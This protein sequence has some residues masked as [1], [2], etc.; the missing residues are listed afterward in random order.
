[1]NNNIPWVEKYRPKKIDE[2]IQQMEVIKILKRTLKTGD[3]P[4]MLFYGP[5]GT[6]KTSTILAIVYELFGPKNINNRVIELNASDDN[7][8][9]SVRNKIIHFAQ[10]CIS[11]PDPNFPS[12][13]YK[14][15]ILDEADAMTTEA[16]SALL[17]V[18]EKTSKHTRFCFICNYMDKIIDQIISRCVTFR[19]KSINR[20]FIYNKLIKIAKNEK[21]E[22]KDSNMDIISQICEG[23]IRKGIMMLQYIKYLNIL[24]K[25]IT[26]EDINNYIGIVN[27]DIINNIWD[28]IINNYTIIE[29]KNIAINIKRNAY[30]ITN[31]LHKL[32]LKIIH[33]KNI[34]E[35]QKG[36][37]L[38]ELSIVDTSLTNGAD[39]YL[40]ILK[41]IVTMKNIF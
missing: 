37:L 10:T 4:H 6:G 11:N 28:C 39:E 27:D 22:I 25:N 3:L 31:I 41:L 23:D 34:T 33:E 15:V 24:N 21:L 1:M 36:Q 40:Q 26:S 16:Q 32:L 19:F 12:P 9:N 5:P 30:S 17:Q 35:T 29:I 18:I 20:D 38:I 14:I 13:P 7:G 2:I 8:I